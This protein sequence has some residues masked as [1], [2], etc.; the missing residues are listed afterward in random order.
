MSTVPKL[1]REK[2]ET[3][4]TPWK[5][6]L[7]SIFEL[8]WWQNRRQRRRK[9]GMRC[10]GRWWR[11]N[12]WQ[13]APPGIFWRRGSDRYWCPVPPPARPHTYL[14]NHTYLRLKSGVH[15]PT[16]EMP[17]KRPIGDRLIRNWQEIWIQS[18][19]LNRGRTHFFQAHT[20]HTLKYQQTLKIDMMTKAIL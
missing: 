17:G 6:V 13:M 3:L 20:Y 5:M 8:Q 1:R 18:C 9:R 15:S 4:G 14:R 16:W 7:L 19:P 2:S 10:W 12:S 11:R